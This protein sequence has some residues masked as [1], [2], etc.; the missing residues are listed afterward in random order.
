MGKHAALLIVDVQNDFCPGGLL[1]V[2][3][4]DR[5]VP[6][7]NR[8][9]ELFRSEGLPVLASRDWHPAQSSHFK[10]FGGIWPVHCVQSSSG[11]EFHPQLELP[12]DTIIFSKGMDPSRDDYSAF[13]GLDPNMQ[14]LPAVIKELGITRLYV[15]GLTT[16]YCVRETVIDGLGCGLA[17]T[18][19]ED[20]I[21]GVDLEAG[22]SERAIAAMKAA[23]ADTATLGTVAANRP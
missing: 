9:I 19:L 8:Y 11:A 21:R 14:P 17:V 12:D 2:R 20:A 13:Q 18:L 16:D 7:L 1:A 22:D 10:Q 23:G 3:D 6:V 15:G 4:G 5:V